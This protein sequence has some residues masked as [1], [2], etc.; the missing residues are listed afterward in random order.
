MRRVWIVIGGVMTGLVGFVVLIAGSWF[1]YLKHSAFYATCL[2]FAHTHPQI[3]ETVGELHASSF[4]PIGFYQESGAEQRGEGTV[5]FLIRG[6]K[7]SAS[8]SLGAYRRFAHWVIDAARLRFGDAAERLDTPGELIQETADLSEAELR[9]RMEHALAIQPDI[10]EPHYLLGE[11]YLERR[12]YPR[13]ERAFREAIARDP[14][15]APGYND[16]GVAL[17]RQERYQDALAIFRQAT[18]IAP[19]D[20]YPY[21]NQAAL[22]VEVRELRDLVLARRLL[23]E[24]AARDPE[25]VVWQETLAA[26]SEAE[27]NPE[28]A[29][30]ARERARVLRQERE[31]IAPKAPAP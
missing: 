2:Q 29:S 9:T 21:L 12:D 20:P 17:M 14:A 8:L 15:Y 16:L 22:Y 11:Y 30:A 23:D 3:R 28:A 6:S 27:G 5:S 31:Q 7:G 26:L 19:D 24:A 25:P 4:F 1:Y 10:P 13:A 18:T